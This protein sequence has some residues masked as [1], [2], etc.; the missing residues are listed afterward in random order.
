MKGP[1]IVWKRLLVLLRTLV[2][3]IGKVIF[4][5]G[6]GVFFEKLKIVF[7]VF[8]FLSTFAI[9]TREMAS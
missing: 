8:D 7:G 6:L 2:L 1:R 9:P 4:M 5:V 3:N